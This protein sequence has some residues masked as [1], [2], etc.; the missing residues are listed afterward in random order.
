MKSDNKDKSE[1]LKYFESEMQKQGFNIEFYIKELS[2]HKQTADN[3]KKEVEYN[4]GWIRFHEKAIKG[5]EEKIAKAI[6]SEIKQDQE[7]KLQW[8]PIIPRGGSRS[9]RK[10]LPE[11]RRSRRH[12]A[13]DTRLRL[14]L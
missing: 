4:H 13:H 8:P 10:E 7:N 14:R 2:K 12:V 6:D 5:H 11:I 3:H 1:R 9:D